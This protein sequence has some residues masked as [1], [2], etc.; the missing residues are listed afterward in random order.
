MKL[1]RYHIDAGINGI[2]NCRAILDGAKPAPIHVNNDH[3]L[4]TEERRRRDLE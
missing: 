4:V 1:D 3:D 2:S